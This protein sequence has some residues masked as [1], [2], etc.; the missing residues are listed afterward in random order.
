[1]KIL[2]FISFYFILLVESFPLLK[3]SLITEE[4]CQ[5][6]R[7]ISNEWKLCITDE[8]NDVDY[9]ID[10]IYLGNICSAHNM[11]Y[12]EGFNFIKNIR[13]VIKPNRL[14]KKILIKQD[15]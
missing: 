10:N 11:S 3:G 12:K 4:Q 8:Y 15:L 6:I 2:F 1:M 5:Y 9:I 14:F 7:T 13:S